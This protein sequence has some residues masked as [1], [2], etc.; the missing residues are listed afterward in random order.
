MSNLLWDVRPASRITPFTG[1]IQSSVKR[2]LLVL[3]ALLPLL[4][5][6]LS[7]QPKAPALP[8]TSGGRL[9][10]ASVN[11]LDSTLRVAVRNIDITKFPNVGIVFDVLRPDVPLL[12]HVQGERFDGWLLLLRH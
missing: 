10:Y 4:S 3:L 12:R 11:L 6:A 9:G 7:A 1:P 2:Y 5:Q 8:D